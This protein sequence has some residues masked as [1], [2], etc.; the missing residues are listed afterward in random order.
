MIKNI[1]FDLGK[2]M[3]KWDP[4]NL[5]RKVFA[6]EKE[7]EQFLEDVCNDDWNEQQDAGRPLAEATALL[8]AA[9]PEYSE[10]IKMYYGR[11]MEMLDG[12]YSENV[13]LM[14][15]LKKDYPVYALTNWSAETMVWAQPM[16]TF[17]DEFDGMVVSG[18]EKVKKP[19]PRIFQILLERY[20]LTA[21]ECLFIDDNQRN[22]AAARALGFQCIHHIPGSDLKVALVEVLSHPNPGRRE[23]E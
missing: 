15:E 3:I 16:F 1:V 19:D 13:A 14:R 2:V 10:Q 7:M 23:S 9:H 5:Y 22:V 18:K 17:L 8:V 6:A 21:E 12:A 11:W 4:R 20:E